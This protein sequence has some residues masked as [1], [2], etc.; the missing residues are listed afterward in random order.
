MQFDKNSL[1][2]QN[3]ITAKRCGFS[4]S[5]NHESHFKYFYLLKKKQL[6]ITQFCKKVNSLYDVSLSQVSFEMTCFFFK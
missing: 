4:S 5:I 2:F 3:T 6:Q 1:T